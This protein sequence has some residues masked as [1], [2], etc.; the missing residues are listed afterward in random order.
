MSHTA[1]LTWGGRTAIVIT[2]A[3]VTTTAKQMHEMMTIFRPCCV[4]CSV[5]QRHKPQ[6]H[7]PTSCNN[8]QC[9]PVMLV[10]HFSLQDQGSFQYRCD[11]VRI[12]IW[13]RSNF[14]RFHQIQN[15]TNVLSA[16]LSNANSQ[17][18][19]CSTTDFMCTSN[20]MCTEPESTDKPVFFSNSTCNTNYSYWMCNIIFAQ[21]CV[22]LYYW[23]LILSTS[24]NNILL[25]SFNW[26]SEWLKAHQQ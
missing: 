23:T 25:Q 18:N 15:L 26:P 10:N 3:M 20:F 4:C 22:K 16:F 2:S 9:Q 21:W 1:Q 12:Q 6:C 5:L 24:G 8:R 14:E 17:K 11:K 7:Q 19:P 13:K